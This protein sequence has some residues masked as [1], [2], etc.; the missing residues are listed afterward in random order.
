MLLLTD[1]IFYSLSVIILYGP[2][3]QYCHVSIS[4]LL[5]DYFGTNFNQAK[6]LYRQYPYQY[7]STLC[8]SNLIFHLVQ[9]YDS[10]AIKHVL[11]VLIDKEIY[12]NQRM[13]NIDIYRYTNN[14]VKW[15]SNDHVL[16]FMFVTL[17]TSQDDISLLNDDTD[18]NI[19]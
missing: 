3:P 10:Y 14:Y 16:T 18:R 5:P 19:H 13:T 11:K 2:V 4:I 15:Y 12:E 9:Q 6:I 7:H 8:I 1:T 17:D